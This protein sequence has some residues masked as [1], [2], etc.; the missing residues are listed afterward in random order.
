M[1]NE[2]LNILCIALLVEIAYKQSSWSNAYLKKCWLNALGSS[3]I[4]FKVVTK[5]RNQIVQQDAFG[6]VAI[7]STKLWTNASDTFVHAETCEK[8]YNISIF[9]VNKL[10]IF[11]FDMYRLFYI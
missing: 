4:G 6:F 11:V 3:C 7:D 1:W 10:R 2:I 8:V 9:Y 5:G